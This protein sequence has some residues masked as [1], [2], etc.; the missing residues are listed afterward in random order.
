[1]DYRRVAAFPG[2]PEHIVTAWTA[3]GA[4]CASKGNATAC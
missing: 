3:K 2:Y 4:T 1:M